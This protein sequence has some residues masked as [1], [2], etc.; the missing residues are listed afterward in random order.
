VEYYKMIESHSL[1]SVP[2][3][4]TKSTIIPLLSILGIEGVWSTSPSY[5]SSFSQSQ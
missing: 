1:K 2:G 4:K 3:T 5:P